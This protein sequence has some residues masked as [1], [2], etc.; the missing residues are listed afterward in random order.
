MVATQST[1]SRSPI[2]IS[3]NAIQSEEEE[4][5]AIAEVLSAMSS[6]EFALK[7]QQFDEDGYDI[8]QIKKDD[9]VSNIR[10][11]E[12][13]Y[14]DD[15]DSDTVQDDEEENFDFS[16]EDY[17]NAEDYLN[18]KVDYDTESFDSNEYISSDDGGYDSNQEM[19]DFEDYS[20]SQDV[21]HD[22][23]GYDTN[24]E[25]SYN[26]SS[27]DFG[28]NDTDDE[29]EKSYQENSDSDKE[30]EKKRKR[31]VLAAQNAP[32]KRRFCETELSLNDNN[33]NG[34]GKGKVVHDSTDDGTTNSREKILNPPKG[35]H[36]CNSCYDKFSTF[37]LN[38]NLDKM[39]T[40]SANLGVI[41]DCKHGFC[42][43][44]MKHYLNSVLKDEVVEFP[45]KCPLK[46]VDAKITERVVENSLAKEDLENYYLKM[47]VSNIKNK[48][49]CPNKKCSALIDY[50]QDEA[51]PERA[52]RELVAQQEQQVQLQ[53]QIRINVVGVG[54]RRDDIFM[55]SD[56]EDEGD[57]RNQG[58]ANPVNPVRVNPAP[59]PPPQPQQ[60]QAKQINRRLNI[61]LGTLLNV[62]KAQKRFRLS[63]WKFRRIEDLESHLQRTTV[64][65]VY[66]CC[67]K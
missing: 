21:N 18:K 33:V 23:E 65:E 54:G 9:E 51:L 66:E 39:A 55:D 62:H 3:G 22:D 13:Q 30:D 27:Q 10:S 6:Y 44:C 12:F 1:H 5:W 25:V 26:D 49:Y 42:L 38:G 2:N 14:S 4:L 20:T 24:K 45:I 58:P 48:I 8:D 37:N 34:K 31:E 46:C 11:C 50:E 43:A 52:R 47:A 28:Y 64:H 17:D 67:G 60:R 36:Q 61:D 56:D 57:H 32:V 16:N 41:L 63:N 53:R 7:L 59:P 15:E 40:S 19:D 29:D 35:N